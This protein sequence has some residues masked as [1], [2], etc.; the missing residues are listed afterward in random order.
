MPGISKALNAKVIGTSGDFV[1]LAHG[2]GSDQSAWSPIADRLSRAY[3]VVLYDLAC[4]GTVSPSF[5][6]QRRHGTLDGHAEDLLAV[7]S[8]LG[9]NRCVFIG[10][11]VSAIVGMLAARVKPHV[12]SKLIML[13]ASA[14][15]LDDDGYEGGLSNADVQG[16]FAAIASNYRNW[17]QSYVP[18]VVDRPG[19]DPATQT[20]LASMLAM[21]PDIALATAKAILLSDYRDVLRDCPC[22][23]W[24]L[25]RNLILLF[26]AQPLS[27]CGITCPE[28]IW[29][30]SR[31]PAICRISALP[32]WSTRRCGVTWP[33]GPRSRGSR[34]SADRAWI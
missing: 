26:R 21:R 6:D 3:R 33:P 2:F 32:I 24:F 22:R 16:I 17:A 29:R 4:A 19:S 27:S 1:V 12:F 7:L 14:R 11:S 5:F 34:P 10:H 18:Y 13:G 25:R 20:F 8:G 15:Y 30:S 9:M 28:A 31:F 23:A